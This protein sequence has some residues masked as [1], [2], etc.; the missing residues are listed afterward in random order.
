MSVLFRT[1]LMAALL[2][3]GSF[4]TASAQSTNTFDGH[5]NGVSQKLIGDPYHCSQ[6]ARPHAITVLNGHIDTP[7]G[8]STGGNLT[9]DVD[10]H[11][12]FV[13]RN[14]LFRID[15]QIDAQGTINAKLEG[16]GTS[17]GGCVWELVWQKR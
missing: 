15:G 8:A 6:P 16:G 5:Y 17:R 11:G 10:P 2:A 12:A 4:T 3:I 1:C 13:L 7:W 9:G 14:G